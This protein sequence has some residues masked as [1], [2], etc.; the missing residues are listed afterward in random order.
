MSTGL[1]AWRALKGFK[2][3]GDHCVFL[4]FLPQV[5]ISETNFALV[6]RLTTGVRKGKYIFIGECYVEEENILSAKTNYDHNY[7]S[8]D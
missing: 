4:D 1:L 2:A 5:H 3:H 8:K 7:F 6:A